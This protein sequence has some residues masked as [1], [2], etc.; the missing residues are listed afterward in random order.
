LVGRCVYFE[1]FPLDFEEF[2]LWKAKDLYKI[3]I[4]FKNSVKE[5]ILSGKI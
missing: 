4:D 5:F 2:L 3:F 1:L